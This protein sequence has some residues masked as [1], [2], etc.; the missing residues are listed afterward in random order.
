MLE[1]ASRTAT[2]AGVLQRQV[3]LADNA[4]GFLYDTGLYLRFRAT[5]PDD[6]HL[7]Y[8]AALAS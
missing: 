8:A 5:G 1:A 2:T 6:F 3:E 7:A 4:L